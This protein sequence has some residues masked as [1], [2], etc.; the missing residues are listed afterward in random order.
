MILLLFFPSPLCF[1]FLGSNI[2]MSELNS[3]TSISP[4]P[5]LSVFHLLTMEVVT[6]VYHVLLLH[7]PSK[8]DIFELPPA[9]QTPALKQYIPIS[10]PTSRSRHRPESRRTGFSSSHDQYEKRQQMPKA[11]Q[12]RSHFPSSSDI[13]LIFPERT[14]YL[15]KNTFDSSTHASTTLGSIHRC[16]PSTM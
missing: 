16:L 11:V 1:I 6:H 14:N 4:L 5:N 7:Y 2:S 15:L 12:K 8:S 9:T 13:I 3:C 10:V